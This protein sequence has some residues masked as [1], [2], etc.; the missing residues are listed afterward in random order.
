M[1]ESSLEYVQG[2][3]VIGKMGKGLRKSFLEVEEPQTAER[4]F[5]NR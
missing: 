4:Y 5:T 3:R 1:G 2:R